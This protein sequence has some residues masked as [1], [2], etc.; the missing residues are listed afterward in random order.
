[1]FT[2]IVGYTALMQRN[3]KMG[4]ETRQRHREIFN[5]ITKKYSGKILQYYGDGTLSVFGSAID[6]VECGIEMQVEFQKE[7][8]IPVRIGIH[9][10][11]VVY[12]QDE[13]IG[14]G[15]NITSRIESLAI[16]G[17][18]YISEKVYD[19]ILNQPN[20][21]AISLGYYELK[22][23]EKPIL[24]YA[25]VHPG[26]TI[27]GKGKLQI[28]SILSSWKKTISAAELD[29][30]RTIK[31][32]VGIIAILLLG[33]FIY[34][35]G[36][37]INNALQKN[38][39]NQFNGAG[40]MGRS[41]AVLPF[42]N[43]SNDPEQE[44]F[45]DGMVD[46]I[47]DHLVKVSEL[48]VIS[49]T[50]S[51]RY[52]NTKLPIRQIGKELG[53]SA[54]LEGSVRKVGNE[55]R[56]AVQLIDTKTDIHIW[57]ETYEGDLSDVFSIQSEVAQNVARGLNATLNSR[58]TDLIKKKSATTSQ[59]AYDF[60]LKGN[61]YWSSKIDAPLALEM[62]TKAINEDSLFI[63]AYA[64]RA[65]IH[66]IYYWLKLEG[67][68]GHDLLAREDIKKGFKLDP[69]SIDVK[70]AE[71]VS[72]YMVDRNY[73][74]SLK[75]LGELTADAPNMADLYAFSSYNLRR[76][77]N[78]EESIVELEKAIQM[79]PLNGNYID[80]LAGTYAVLHRYDE[81]IEYARHGLS[82]IPDYKNLNIKIFRAIMSKTGD[83]TVALKESGLSEE[84]VRYEAY[85][86]T[87]QYDKLI[88]FINK[89]FTNRVDQSTYRPK[90][91]ELAFIYHLMGDSQMSKIYSDSAIIYL[92]NKIKEFP[93]D[94][95]IY[96]TL[97][98]SYAISGNIKK[99]LFFGQKSVLLLPITLDAYQGP[100]R[101]QD[102]ME[103]YIF[104]GNYEKALD[105]IEFLSKAPSRI[106]RGDL[107]SDPIYDKLR[108]LPRFQRII[109][110][111]Q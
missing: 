14:D 58:E 54:I 107:V 52:K 51:M 80:N 27:P 60:Y 49:R 9:F 89:N 24:I 65:F 102:L 45:T 36:H 70:F 15:V 95:R 84:D 26:L 23:V 66:L 44:Y 92:E 71:A 64:R 25:I 76:Q 38:N 98:K 1:M 4:I 59:L 91:Y 41:I 94:D 105:K 29:S 12:S 10:G 40:V 75:V 111:A 110:P 28:T 109:N 67:W 83:F 62:Y 5:Q 108:N 106:S 18:V 35:Y 73:N 82:L 30:K 72:Y 81:L 99:A 101:E 31:S 6:A 97:G 104:T 55:V 68:T 22:N 61:D 85:Y 42:L 93:K 79:D 39:I 43:L 19:E 37:D 32:G 16:P 46:E 34:F 100:V 48:K 103:I 8:K 13:I 88:D 3:E 78:W 33:Y 21:K 69:K 86:F 2:D 17:S 57:S 7:P 56:I 63:Q 87:G 77:G 50:S 11:D 47:I 53:V 20:L 74:K 96:A 90:T